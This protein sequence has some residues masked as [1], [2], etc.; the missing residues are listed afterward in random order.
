[1]GLKPR[2]RNA[3]S[4]HNRR[5]VADHE[6]VVECDCGRDRVRITTGVCRECSWEDGWS[7]AT[8]EAISAMRAIGAPCTIYDLSSDLGR[9]E[10]TV[11]RTM[12]QLVAANRVNR[13]SDT[14]P[15]EPAGGCFTYYTLR[16]V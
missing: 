10:R 16:G 5:A 9:T 6:P 15:G 8:S 3:P 13:T 12:A 2:R 11:W 1:M 4:R 7:R 14:Q